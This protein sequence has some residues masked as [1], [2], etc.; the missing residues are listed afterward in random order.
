MHLPP[1]Y[2]KAQLQL[3]RHVEGGYYKRTYCSALKTA[4][5]D[6]PRQFPDERALSSAIYFLLESGDFSAFHR[7]RSDEMWHFYTGDT[8]HLYEI[9]PKGILNV[10]KLGSNAEAGEKFQV[11][12]NSGNWFAARVEDPGSYTL[13]GCTVTPAFDFRDFELATRDQLTHTFPLHKELIRNLTR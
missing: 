2:W 11:M 1:D 6:N 4:N 5:L 12:I 8:L 7:I 13:V 3:E 9:T 10:H